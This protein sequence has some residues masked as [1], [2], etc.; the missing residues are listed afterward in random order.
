MGIG[1]SVVCRGDPSRGV[2][3]GGLRGLAGSGGEICRLSGKFRRLK[4]ALRPPKLREGHK[5]HKNYNVLD[6][7]HADR[8]RHYN[9]LDG[10]HDLMLVWVE[11]F[12]RESLNLEPREST[13][14]QLTHPH[15]PH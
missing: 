7:Q 8:L 9:V 2:V 4:A 15:A 13:L 3:G 10:H 12:P 6:S 14:S 1:V 5:T 11:C